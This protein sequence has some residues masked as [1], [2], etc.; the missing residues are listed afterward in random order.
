MEAW[1][2]ALGMQLGHH[3][4]D[5]PLYCTLLGGGVGRWASIC[6]KRLVAPLST[7]DM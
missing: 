2:H 7:C 4:P 6:A 5:Q 3:V 1:Q